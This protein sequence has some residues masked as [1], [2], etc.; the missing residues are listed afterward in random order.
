M[1]GLKRMFRQSASRDKGIVWLID[2]CP[3][4]RRMFWRSY[5]SALQRMPRTPRT[6]FVAAG[7]DPGV[8]SEAV[9]LRTRAEKWA[10]KHDAWQASPYETTLFLDND[11]VV[12][13]DVSGLM[14]ANAFVTALP[15]PN[16]H[17]LSRIPCL[18]ERDL[19]ERWLNVNS[20]VAIFSRAFLAEYRRVWVRFGDRALELP[21]KDQCLFSLALRVAGRSWTPSGCLQATA[22][23]YA[24]KNLAAVLGVAEDPKW[25]DVPVSLLSRVCV[26]HYTGSPEVKR[27]Y[28][29]LLDGPFP[30]EVRTGRAVVEER[31]ALEDFARAIPEKLD[32]SPSKLGP[33]G[34]G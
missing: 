14:E 15:Y 25:G 32:M 33:E 34:V 8:G 24:A 1:D 23:P 28:L 27:A 26:F 22:T 3:L 16:E 7:P 6:V 30:A 17:V 10:A 29:R 18:K 4:Q 21:G 19:P 13:A 31:F 20:G 9:S 5:R 12:L 2:D 11:T